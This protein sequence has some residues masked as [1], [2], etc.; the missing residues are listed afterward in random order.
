MGLYCKEEDVK[1][2]LIG[3][4]RFT[5]DEDDENKMS[6][7]LLRRLIKEAESAV[8]MD[9]SPRYMA[10]F[11]TTA[12]ERFDKLPDRPTKEYIRTMCE[13]KAVIRV[14]ETDFGSGSAADAT[15]YTQR[16]QGRYNSM[17]DKLIKKEKGFRQ[18]KFPPLPEIRL[19]FH[20]IEADDG[21]AGQILVTGQGDG[22]FPQSQIN[23]PSENYWNT[24]IDNPETL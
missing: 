4:V 9:L 13:L 21:Y 6:N 5:D 8:E 17:A 10:P 23:D 3:K 2:R 16:Q 24:E 22:D 15:K 14:L 18:W 11:Q 19:N 7:K 20:N 1:V 12:G